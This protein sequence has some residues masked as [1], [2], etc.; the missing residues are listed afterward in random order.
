MATGDLTQ[1]PAVQVV[2]SRLLRTAGEAGSAKTQLALQCLA[3]VQLPRELG[4]LDGSAVYIYTEG[5]PPLKRMSQL[6]QGNG[7]P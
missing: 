1:L 6:L 3:R 2:T 7:T 4:G 5:D